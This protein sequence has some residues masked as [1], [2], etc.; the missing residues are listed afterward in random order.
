MLNFDG[1]PVDPEVLQR[2]VSRLRHRGPDDAGTYVD[3]AVGLGHARLSI[4]DV[5]TGHQ[6]MCNAD[7]TVWLTFNGEIFNYIELRQE[8][9]AR[10]HRF[11]TRSD[12]EVILRL[13]EEH[14]ADCVHRLNGQWAFAIWD[15]PR[16]R[17][18]M[19]R[20]RLG[21]L[22][23]FYTK[24]GSTL[25][26]ASEIKAL[27]T[28]P[29]VSRT[30]DTHALDQLFTFWT[31]LPGKTVFS[32]ISE[33]PAGHTLTAAAGRV[34]TRRYWQ[35]DF[36]QA[37][38][39]SEDEAA[40]R[41]LDLL[42]DATRM[43]LR[44]D[45][46]VGAYLSG[47]L[48]SSTVAAL[49]ARSSSGRPRTFSL[50]F[51][52]SEFDESSYQREVAAQ[53]DVEHEEVRCGAADIG[54]I[55]PAVV[56][57]AERPML[58][59]A[60]APLFLLSRV[61]AERGYKVV[62]TGE[63]ADEILG[64]YDIFK[65]AKIRRFISRFPSSRMRRTLLRRLYPYM[66]MLQAQPDAYL[67]AFFNA[68]PGDTDDPCFSHVPRW[69][70]TSQLK[71]F[72]SAD[73][74]ARVNGYDARHELRNGL[75]SR[76]VD[77]DPLARAQYL[78]AAHLLPGY[79][80]AAQGDRMAMA[81]GVEQR[82][83]FLDHRVVEFGASLPPRLRMKVLQEKYLLKRAT[84]GLVPDRVR[85]RAKQPYRAP[86]AR[87]FISAGGLSP[88]YVDAL[89]SPGRVREDG[90]FDSSAVTSLVTKIRSG[91]PIGTR[92]HMALVGILSTQIVV[93]QFIRNFTRAD[94]SERDPRL[95]RRE[96]PVRPAAH[97]A[98]V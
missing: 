40:G 4:I 17:L 68:A 67:A 42:S 20:D 43:R 14:G 82:F 86:D 16:R 91:R 5:A 11:T 70:S 85:L 88:E 87:S 63:G 48:D 73:L 78:E 22:P 7:G 55:F 97:H 6:P 21:I 92:D 50:T 96:L 90:L 52:E 2:M 72:Y 54:R 62:L 65:E 41:L 24:I 19:S 77:W 31:P 46:S 32:G 61:V 12:T 13:Y 74:R 84:I 39:T 57:H 3:G 23:L 59:T 76:H 89:L 36:P 83:P 1:S 29:C 9:A 56:W 30:I 53:L 95:R 45:V 37:P 8:L 35:L 49:A 25:L 75:P 44:A 98:G 79:I 66:P 38:Q 69:N 93:D 27:F 33:V 71:R 34:S 51:D 60:P 80:L 28:N 94:D 15:A 47:G 26:F 81:H 64:G 10:G 58:R 18:L